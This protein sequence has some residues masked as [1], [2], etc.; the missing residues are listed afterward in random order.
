MDLIDTGILADFQYQV[1]GLTPVG[2]FVQAPVTAGCPQRPLGGYVH[3][4]G[5]SGID[6]DLTYMLR[7]L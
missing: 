7:I 6:Q 3:Q 1:P 2:G 4:V 5:V